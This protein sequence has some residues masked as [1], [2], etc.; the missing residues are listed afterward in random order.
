MSGLPGRDIICQLVVNFHP[1]KL[2]PTYGIT[3]FNP[4]CG[5]GVYEFTIDIVL[6]F[7]RATGLIGD[8][9]Q[10]GVVDGEG[11]SCSGSSAM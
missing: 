7:G 4:L 6:D 5:F 10:D 3:K 9:L 11:L 8:L 1:E 2:V